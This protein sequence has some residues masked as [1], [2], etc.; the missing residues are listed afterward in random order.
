MTIGPAF[1][2]TCPHCGGHK[3]IESIMS[4]NTFRGT[5]WSD[6]KK[7]YPMLPSP[8]PIQI[9]PK[10][11][12][13]YFYEDGKPLSMD[14]EAFKNAIKD[15]SRLDD[16]EI[17]KQ[18]RIALR[19]W[20]KEAG[21]N[22]FGLLNEQESREAYAFLYSDSLPEQRKANVLI[23][24]LFSFNDEYLRMNN[25]LPDELQETQEEFISKIISQFANEKL[26]VAELYREVGQF[27]KAKELL[28]S[29]LE[30]DIDEHSAS[31]AKKILDYA[32]KQDRTVFVLMEW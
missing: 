20:D 17:E 22:G 19:S 2:L 21:V 18:Y 4:G 15:K 10:C 11:G 29:F 1:R 26:F 25:T 6:G 3:Y 9:C 13:Y 12:K 30:S 31:A 32:E 28:T 23:T 8:S 27:E 7:D 5:M 16:A 14:F 24:R